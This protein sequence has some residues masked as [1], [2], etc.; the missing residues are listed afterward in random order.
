MVCLSEGMT[1]TNHRNKMFIQPDQ[2]DQSIVDLLEESVSA[3][4]S[5]AEWLEDVDGDDGSGF[6]FN[7]DA[8][9]AI[10][11]LFESQIELFRGEI[12]LETNIEN[13]NKIW[14]DFQN[15][16]GLAN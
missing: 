16:E 4:Q 1:L 8:Y 9:E 15:T 14:S 12:D 10:Q 7:W 13:M 6:E 5:I 3:D 2:L 11:S